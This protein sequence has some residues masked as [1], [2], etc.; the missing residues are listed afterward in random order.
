MRQDQTCPVA[1]AERRVE[2][3]HAGDYDR[4]A[5][6][7]AAGRARVR[8]LRAVAAELA[9]AQPAEG[10]WQAAY[11][12]VQESARSALRRFAHRAAAR[13]IRSRP[14]RPRSSGAAATAAASTL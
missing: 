8:G 14:R 5:A 10:E 9:S 2:L 13:L 1:C 11:L 6:S 4:L 3:V 7:A 12:A